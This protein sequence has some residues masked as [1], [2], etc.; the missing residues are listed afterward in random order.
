MPKRSICERRASAVGSC[1]PKSSLYEAMMKK[2]LPPDCARWLECGDVK[3]G[4]D[5]WNT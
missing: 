2:T 4:R 1:R 5:A 3:S